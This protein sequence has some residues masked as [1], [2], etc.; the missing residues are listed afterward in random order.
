[1]SDQQVTTRTERKKLDVMILLGGPGSERDVSIASGYQVTRALRSAGHRV[2]PV[3]LSKG[4]IHP[5]EEEKMLS[6]PVGSVPPR[7]AEADV[8]VL[9]V[10]AAALKSQS[11]DLC[12][13]ALHGR[14]GE[15][16]SIQAILD[17]VHIPYTGSGAAASA[18]AFD[19][20]LS[21]KVLRAAGVKTP[22]WIAF[23]ANLVSP[24]D[25]PFGYP[26]I[27][28]PC[29]QGST[30]G[31]AVARS[32]RELEDAVA[33]ARLHDTD[34][35]YERFVGGREL[36]VGVL[37]DEVLAIGEILLGD[38]LIFDYESKYQP[39]YVQEKFPAALDSKTEYAVR[40]LA[41]EAHE[42]LGLTGYSRTDIRLDENGEPFCLEV[43]TLP[44][45]TSTSLLPQSALKANFDFVQLCE[46]IC[47]LALVR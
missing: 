17:L 32:A 7:T 9:D 40:R 45:L 30:I 16:G 1:M 3:D 26:V 34:V 35:M 6:V 19:K 28:K 11:W 37:G 36:T 12:F 24:P 20:D 29:R 10:L 2:V 47:G 43:N 18:I 5:D 41:R 33:S 38:R 13:L 21:K 31:I 25:N 42:A 22:D 4:P 39:S 27:V 14:P 8:S 23:P 46:K 15:D 44:G